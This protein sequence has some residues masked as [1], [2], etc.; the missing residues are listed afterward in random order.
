MSAV[1]VGAGAALLVAVAARLA[2]MAPLTVARVAVAE[3]VEPAWCPRAV[4]SPKVQIPVTAGFR[5]LC[6][7]PKSGILKNENN[8]STVCSVCYVI[9]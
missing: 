2:G 7:D 5:F 9:M 3:P 4:Q 1:A 8:F 6:N